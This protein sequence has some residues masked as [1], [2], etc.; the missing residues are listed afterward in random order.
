MISKLTPI[1]DNIYNLLTELA[2][3]SDI[4]I[5]GKKFKSKKNK[6]NKKNI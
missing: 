3:K 6:I 5:G 4:K 2:D 1:C